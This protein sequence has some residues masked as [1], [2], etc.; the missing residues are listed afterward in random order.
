MCRSL[1][2]IGLKEPGLSSIT[3]SCHPA[4]ATLAATNE[5]PGAI[6]ARKTMSPSQLRRIVFTRDRRA[7]GSTGPGAGSSGKAQF[8]TEVNCSTGG[9]VRSHPSFT[10]PTQLRQ[11]IL[12]GALSPLISK[13]NSFRVDR[14]ND[15]RA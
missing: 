11:C 7:M 6:E 5:P 10:A 3:H 12:L 8:Q 9:A 14:A 4:K 2:E 1:R 13:V 15:R